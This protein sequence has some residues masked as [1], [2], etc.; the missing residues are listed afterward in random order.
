MSTP[1]CTY[2][3]RTQLTSFAP[4]GTWTYVGYNSSS[5][6]GP[7]SQTPVVPL[8]PELSGTTINRGDDFAIITDNK[9]FGYYRFN[10]T[11][12]T[13]TVSLTIRV[14]D[15]IITSGVSTSITLS[16]QDNPVDLLYILGGSANGVWTDLDSA[17][18]AFNSGTNTLTPT[19]LTPGNTYRF[20]Y[21]LTNGYA[22]GGCTSCPSLES[23]VTV[24]IVSGFSARIDATDDTCT[25]T[26]ALKNPDDNVSNK[27]KVV[28][29]AD[30]FRPKFTVKRVVTD[31]NSL[32]VAD[33]VV[34][35]AA[36]T[37]L[38]IGHNMGT[39]PSALQTGGF[40]ETLTLTNSA[41]GTV[42]VPLAPSGANQAVF[43][44]VGGSTTASALT[45]AAFNTSAYRDALQI[46]IANSLGAQGFFANTHY[47]LFVRVDNISG[48]GEVVI[49]FFAKHQPSSA[50]LGY[51]TMS[52]RVTSSSNTT[53]AGINYKFYGYS[54][55]PATYSLGSCGYLNVLPA[56]STQIIDTS[57]STYNNIVLTGSTY[58][59]TV[60]G[61]SVSSLTCTSKRLQAVPLNCTGNTTYLW[62]YKGATTSVI[63]VFV[64]GT[65][66]VTLTCD[67]PVATKEV[68]YVYS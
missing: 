45:F 18:G 26:M 19:T 16:T 57:T 46:A 49:G 9:S 50:W 21:S 54:F 52:Y 48:T 20:K 56:G 51:N 39:V 34:E 23:T 36:F 38:I 24:S 41:G 13:D 55:I 1:K 58:V 15:D 7:W 61:S 67:N 29:E 35:V 63:E 59:F 65:Y 6:A 32:T 42:T 28:I 4:G 14:I 2:N 37:E 17:G 43:T 68:I 10:Y 53:S 40:I 27:A 31:C 66:K 30:S 12:G 62:D 33:D 64:K 25:F 5:D 8:V 22:Q 47:R 44:G 11:I 3:I 60:D